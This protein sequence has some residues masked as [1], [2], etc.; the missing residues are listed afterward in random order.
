MSGDCVMVRTSLI[1]WVK[2]LAD[3]FF[4]TDSINFRYRFVSVTLCLYGTEKEVSYTRHRSRDVF[5]L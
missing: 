5:G 2:H 1:R 3:Q 4:V